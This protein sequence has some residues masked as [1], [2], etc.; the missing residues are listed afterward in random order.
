M[1]VSAAVSRRR[2][3][4]PAPPTHTAASASD[5][6]SGLAQ[7][8]PLRQGSQRKTSAQTAKVK[9]ARWI[10]SATIPGPDVHRV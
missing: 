8:R 5:D 7:A 6:R 3:A 2:I 9:I 1:P 10:W 4:Q